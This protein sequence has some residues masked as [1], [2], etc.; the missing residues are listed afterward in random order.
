M[1]GLNGSRQV[2]FKKTSRRVFVF[3]I[4]LRIDFFSS[5]FFIL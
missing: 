3:F 4:S 2:H 1:T 5:S